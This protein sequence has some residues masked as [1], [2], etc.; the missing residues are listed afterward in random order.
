MLPLSKNA[1]LCEAYDQAYDAVLL[2]NLLF[3]ELCEKD[4]GFLPPTA[5]PFAIEKN[6]SKEAAQLLK[7][8]LGAPNPNRRL[9]DSLAGGI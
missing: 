3:L 9:L 6:L 5:R 2:L 1:E 7:D 4:G 8:N